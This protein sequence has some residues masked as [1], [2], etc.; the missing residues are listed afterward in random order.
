[1]VTEL[2]KQNRSGSYISNCVKPV[3]SWLEFN[4][5]QVQQRIKIARRDELVRTAD[6]RP[7]T[8]EE[9]KR[10]F[11]MADFRT[12]VACALV[13]F[14]GVR[15]EVIGNYLGKDGLQLRDFPELSI[16]DRNVEFSKIPTLILV[17]KS[18]SKTRNQFFTFLSEEGCEYLKEYLEFRLMT[19]T[20][21]PNSPVIT[22]SKHALSGKHIRTVNVSDLI[23]KPIRAAAFK[24]RPYVLRRYF[25]TR[26]MMAESDALLIRDYRIFWMGHKGDMEHTYTV[27]KGLS[28][29]VVEKMRESYAKAAA[30]YLQ[31]KKSEAGEDKIKEAVKKHLLEVVGFTEKDF[32]KRDLNKMSNDEILDLM[33]QK[34][35]GTSATDGTNGSKNGAKQK[36]IPNGQLEQYVEGGWEYVATAG[37]KIVVKM[38]A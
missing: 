12:R 15:I 20:L 34:L 19:E 1:M 23:R 22:P 17:R 18:L 38:P 33:K 26:L 35:T 28:Q 2:E 5:I 11:D 36:V 29:D 3:K 31:T 27:N 6:E 16:K 13:A 30:K 14:S 10:I 4:G 9:L 37:E 32:A 8:P 7:P 21:T 24:W 25:D